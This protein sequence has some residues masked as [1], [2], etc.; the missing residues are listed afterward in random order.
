MSRYLGCLHLQG[1]C[2]MAVI[3]IPAS[4]Q[5]PRAS[6]A[7]ETVVLA[8]QEP[9]DEDDED[10]DS[11]SIS[12]QG[13]SERTARSARQHHDNA[14]GASLARPRLVR[15]GAP[16]IDE[17]PAALPAQLSGRTMK[18]LIV[19]SV[20]YQPL[21][22]CSCN[23]REESISTAPVP[24]CLPAPTPVQ[25]AGV[26]RACA[27]QE[28]HSAVPPAARASVLHVE[29]TGGVNLPAT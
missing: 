11:V 13:Q 8:A 6:P 20:P 4:R 23:A 1:M 12:H 7:D 27:S 15:V 3:S 19:S 28:P 18:P 26:Q 16:W 21:L 29:S 2:A 9:A 25:F 14:R 22:A 24:R 10:S 17:T 5:L